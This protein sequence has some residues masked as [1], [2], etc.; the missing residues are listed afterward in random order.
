MIEVRSAYVVKMKDVN[1]TMDLWRQG[2]DQ[3]WPLLGWTGRIQQ[4]LHGH[5]QQSLMVWS[6]DWQNMAEWEAGMAR[7][8]D[9]KEYKDWSAEMNR[10]R[11]Y[12][13][14]REV[15]SILEPYQALDNTPRKVEVRSSYF[16]QM[17]NVQKAKEIMR[18]G[19]E[20]V[21]PLLGWSGQ[22]QQMLHGKASQ[23]L[24]VWTSAWDNLAA[25]E[26]AMANTRGEEF[27]AWYRDWKEVA[28]FGGPR[29]IFR[30]L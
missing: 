14:E 29:E 4:M 23:S 15:F 18:R 1:Q 10:L 8:R 9:C 25:W 5:T 7:T 12:G 30:N 16:V 28:D 27:Q 19:Q 26:T 20:Q 17:V 21:W 11:V 22:N 3:I 2:R 6:S 24:Y 13:D